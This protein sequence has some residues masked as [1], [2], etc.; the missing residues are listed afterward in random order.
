MLKDEGLLGL[1]LV[2]LLQPVSTLPESPAAPDFVV[3]ASDGDHRI[4]FE[5]AVDRVSQH[6]H[7][8]K[9][10]S[11]VFEPELEV[12]FLQ[13]KEPLEDALGLPRCSSGH[14]APRAPDSKSE[15][16]RW[17]SRFG[18]NA[19]LDA[20]LRERIASKLDLSDHSPLVALPSYRQLLADLEPWRP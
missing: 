19:T 10:L 11:I 3:L 12:L 2:Q 8:T 17:L 9:V 14:P 7:P 15:L 16:K 4:K 1:F 13:G 20:R 6:H 5:R 18:P